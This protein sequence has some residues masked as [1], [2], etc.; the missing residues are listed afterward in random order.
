MTDNS[1]KNDSYKKILIVL[2]LFLLA[3]GGFLYWSI[4]YWN[5]TFLPGTWI[6]GIYVAGMT[7]EEVN[8]T[9]LQETVYP[10]FQVCIPVRDPMTG[11]RSDSE[12]NCGVIS[13][14]EQMLKADYSD[15]LFALYNKRLRNKVRS[16]LENH[17]DT[18]ILPSFS[19]RE[20]GE[21]RFRDA[22]YSLSCVDEEINGRS[23][24][25]LLVFDEE[26]GYEIAYGNRSVFQAETAIS[27]CKDSLC[28]GDSVC[29]L[30]D[31]QIYTE[32]VPKKAEEDLL[33]VYRDLCYFLDFT[34]TYDMGA[35]QLYL[36]KPE[37]SA[38]LVIDPKS[39][40]PVQDES[41]SFLWDEELVEA[42]VRNLC[43]EYDTLGIPR[44]YTTYKGDTVHLEKGTYGTK[45]SEKKEIKWL[46]DA[47]NLHK[48]TTHVPFYEK[49][50][51]QRGL[52]DVGNTYIEVD[53]TGQHLYFI[54]NGELKLDT[55]IVTGDILRHRE[56]PT[57]IYYIYYRQKNRV[58]RGPGYA[59]FVHYWMAVKNGVGIH[60]ATWRKEFGGSIYENGGSHG[61]INVPL[62]ITEKLYPETEIG[63]PV[64]IYKTD[65]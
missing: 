24:D 57:G 43:S 21:E 63:M 40:L 4:R 59:S 18:E 15:Q 35:E 61:C 53:I 2:L 31:E 13:D 14:T 36:Q 54:Q 19:F 46:N 8:K 32:V 23:F 60:D 52:D 42:F 12:Y 55:P 33:A 48:N 56:T 39:G 51:Y 16:V 5:R 22:F 11:N 50:P 49:E 38:L 34:I 29:I 20:T 10:D 65:E 58:L 17:T 28:R 47:L 44:E 64:I 1:V 41:G 25:I 3:A 30:E 26:K 62:D 37:L 27:I 9:L 6:N 45:I 7:V